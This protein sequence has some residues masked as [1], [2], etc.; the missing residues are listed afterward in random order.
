MLSETGEGLIKRE[1]MHKNEKPNLPPLA[2]RDTPKST[3][4]VFS[5]IGSL[6]ANAGHQ[7]SKFLPYLV[8]IIFTL[9]AL[10]Y[11]NVK[12]HNKENSLEAQITDIFG[13][14][15]K[16][17]EINTKE[18]SQSQ[19]YCS[20]IK[21]TKCSGT[22]LLLKTLIDYLRKR[23][24]LIDCTS[25]TTHKPVDNVEEKT[26]L[27]SLHFKEKCVHV[28]EVIDY[29]INKQEL[30]KN[31]EVNKELAIDSVLKAIVKNSH[32]EILL[33]NESYLEVSDS[34]NVTYLISLISSKSFFCRVKELIY[35]IYVRA[36]IFGM[37]VIT[38]FLGYLVFLAYKKNKAAVDQEYFSL[39]SQVTA[40]VEKQYE[41][42]LLDPVNIKPYIAISHIYDTLVDPSERATKKKL[43]NKIVNFIQ[44][45]ESRIHLETQFINGEETHVWKWIVAKHESVLKN[46]YKDT[47]IGLANSTMIN[48]EALK[49]Q[50]QNSIQNIPT[51]NKPLEKQYIEPIQTN[52]WQGSAFNRSE[53][54]SHYPTPCL[55]IRNMFDFQMLDM[56]S[57][58]PQKIHN[59]ILRKCLISNE[60]KTILHISCDKK[61]KEGCVYVKCAS[62]KAA[63]EVYEALDGSWYN[64][65]LLKVKFLRND[66]Y[67]ERFPES[68]NFTQ[69]IKFLKF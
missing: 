20:D 29:L 61:S 16:T 66:R 4:S 25:L 21:D 64:G 53:K 31:P 7:F 65:K 50:S 37:A 43:W 59:D 5:K 68:I 36:V 11:I 3:T 13:Q 57:N 51:S 38:L 34:E 62:N 28:N 18:S 48:P 15:H 67:L 10:Q 49:F 14:T 24:G 41:L 2:T 58:L 30:V 40:M 56:D 26:K 42:S 47:G 45:H 35:F 44:D 52:G 23:S 33:L 69:P 1:P 55:K 63:G 32:W 6:I 46:K 9:A 22:K 17:S 19:I 8:I 27:A 54:L 60:N 39:I 12:F